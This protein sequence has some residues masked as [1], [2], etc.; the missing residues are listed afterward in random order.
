MNRLNTQLVHVNISPTITARAVEEA[1]RQTKAYG[2]AGLCLPPFWINKA[3]RELR[4]TGTALITVVGHPYGYQMTQTKTAE[5]QQAIADGASELQLALN[6]SA[7]K[8]GMP[9]V[10]IEIAKCAT[11][12]HQHEV[13]LTVGLDLAYLNEAE[14]T[15]VATQCADAGADGVQ[16]LTE[17]VA[18]EVVLSM[19][20]RLR[21]G[22]PTSVTLEVQREVSQAQA[23]A[24][25]QLGVE[26]IATPTAV[27]LV[28][29]EKQR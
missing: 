15:A 28:S 22:L 9:W 23:Q 11:L 20:D 10:K 24:L 16:L 27:S 4:A 2:L 8:S 5:M 3:R 25:L 21:N 6:L 1:V 7:L 12:A 13:L 17:G 26:R 29:D 19:V 14:A 18:K